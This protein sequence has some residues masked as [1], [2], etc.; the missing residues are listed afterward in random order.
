MF[1]LAGGAISWNSAKQDAIAIS[2]M[3]AEFIACFEAT[4]HELWLWNFVS[5]LGVIDSIAKPF[6]IFCDNA[7]AIFF[8]KND[9]YSNSAKYM[10]IKYL[11]LKKEVQKQKVFIEH[12]STMLI[13]VDPLTKG[14]G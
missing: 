14:L 10:D 11:T 7:T 13:T 9:K 8:S 5:R 6:R 3:E 1:L 12:I 2:T 4:N